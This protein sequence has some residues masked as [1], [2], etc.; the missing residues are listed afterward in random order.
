MKAILLSAGLGSRLHPLTIDRPKCLVPVE[1]RMILDRQIDALR[2]NGVEEITV[3]VG[4]RAERIAAHVQAMPAR[5]RPDLLFNPYWA[6]SSSIISV[7]QARA[8]L[9]QPFCL[10]NGDTIFDADLF[11]KALLRV[12]GG[13][14][15]L[16]ERS[17][18]AE[19]DMRV[20]ADQG[21]VRAV[22]KGLAPHR[23]Q[24][25]S[26]GIVIC[27]D[28]DGG[29]YRAALH[30]VV[31]QKNG[32]QQFHHAVIDRLAKV[33]TVNPILVRSSNWSEID[34]PEDIEEWE[35]RRAAAFAE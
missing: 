20:V 23:A 11:A 10:I 24:L 25:R 3:V 15:L 8:L 19:D 26:L 33:T 7:W 2:A 13:I 12:E 17:A 16:V 14:N 5:R 21:R 27:P 22:G 6:V 34:R 28:P 35:H 1:G 32:H 18:P 9:R 30:D 29:P 31:H 4:Y